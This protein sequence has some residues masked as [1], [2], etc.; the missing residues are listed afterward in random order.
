MMRFKILIDFKLR[1]EY[2]QSLKNKKRQVMHVKFDFVDFD[3]SVV[4]VPNFHSRRTKD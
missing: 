4:D 2:I 3:I 1:D